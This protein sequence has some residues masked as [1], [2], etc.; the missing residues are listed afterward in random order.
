MANED[1]FGSASRYTQP[2]GYA[3][4]VPLKD[5][6]TLFTNSLVG[7]RTDGF[8]ENA[9][10]GLAA[11]Y[12]A[13]YVAVE[14][15]N[16]VGDAA[17]GDTVAQQEV[18]DGII[19]LLDLAATHNATDLGVLVYPTTTDSHTVT[20]T[21]LIGGRACGRI[22]ELVGTQQAMVYINSHIQP[23][24]LNLSQFRAV[25][26]QAADGTPTIQGAG[27]INTTGL[28]VPVIARS[29]AGVFTLTFTA[30]IL[31]ADKVFLGVAVTGDGDVSAQIVRTST[32]VVTI[33]TFKADPADDFNGELYVNIEIYG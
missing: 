6:T 11:T 7:L 2:K 14:S 30:A 23:I 21:P 29:G 16:A 5:E 3:I 9:A 33:E 28:A 17:D 15:I 20:I 10:S 18:R 4:P 19:L 27:L 24:F 1:R 31:I 8:V 25:Y 22:V 13:F 26:D 12:D 32:T